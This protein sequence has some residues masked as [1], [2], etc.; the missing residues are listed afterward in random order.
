MENIN[1]EK[2]KGSILK[3]TAALNLKIEHQNAPD[4]LQPDLESVATFLFTQVINMS[5]NYWRRFH[6]ET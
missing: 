2:E 3:K 5:S 1:K 6:R 4:N